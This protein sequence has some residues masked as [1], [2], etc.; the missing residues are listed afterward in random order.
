MPT[1]ASTR[2][3]IRLD[4]MKKQLYLVNAIGAPRT[5]KMVFEP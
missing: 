2:F 4:E 1:L 3:S 5:L